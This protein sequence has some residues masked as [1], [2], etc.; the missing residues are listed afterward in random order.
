[1]HREAIPVALVALAIEQPDGQPL[2]QE[3]RQ[4]Q[5]LEPGQALP[6]RPRELRQLREQLPGPTAGGDDQVACRIFALRR[7]HVD[8]IAARLPTE[9]RFAR[10]DL[11]ANSLGAGDVGDDAAFRAQEAAFGLVQGGEMGR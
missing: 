7:F 10:A 2:R 11:R 1:M 5:R 8:G 4:I 6:L 3:E 9:Q